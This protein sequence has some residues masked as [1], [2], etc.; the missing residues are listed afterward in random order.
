MNTS[1]TF[2]LNI[3]GC[4]R[5]DDAAT[6]EVEVTADYTPGRP[7]QL[8]GEPGD[9]YPEEAAEVVIT[10]L[11]IS[12]D[13]GGGC[14]PTSPANWL[15]AEL[16]RALIEEWEAKLIEDFDGDDGRA[17]YL[18]DRRKDDALDALRHNF[19]QITGKAAE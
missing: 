8:Y 10:E 7:A 1:G 15:L 19:K 6:I 11:K 16:P 17:D 3:G 4:G 9:C 13:V 12:H 2:E 18:H 5:D 14:F